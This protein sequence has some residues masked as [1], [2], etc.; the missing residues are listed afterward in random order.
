MCWSKSQWKKVY[1]FSKVGENGV[2]RQLGPEELTE[3]LKKLIQHASSIET[4]RKEKDPTVTD[5]IHMLV[6]KR[7]RH[8]FVTDDT[9]KFYIGRVISQVGYLRSWNSSVGVMDYWFKS[10]TWF[11]HLKLFCFLWDCSLMNLQYYLFV[12]CSGWI[13]VC[14]GFYWQLPLNCVVNLFN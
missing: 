9:E 5:R 8:R 1:A 10:F 12:T 2:R 11:R 6:G 7:V 3:N 4:S 13:L 14:F